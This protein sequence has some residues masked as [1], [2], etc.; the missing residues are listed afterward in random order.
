[1]L[2]VVNIEV[3]VFGCEGVGKT[4]TIKALCGLPF[5]PE[6]SVLSEQSVYEGI[7]Y[8]QGN[9]NEHKGKERTKAV[10]ARF[11]SC[12]I[13][14][15]DGTLFEIVMKR[16]SA[17]LILYDIT[18]KGSYEQA[19]DHWYPIVLNYSDCI[20]LVGTKNDLKP[21]AIDIKSVESFASQEDLYFM[22][23]S[24]KSGMNIPLL[25]SILRIR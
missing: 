12:E 7:L 23:V 18:D 6:S 25:Q 8:T 22:E 16:A 15:H 14:K 20:I 5:E 3:P 19:L 21:R 4:S 10:K 2:S 9:R 13:F 24:A 17:S 1:M 11:Y